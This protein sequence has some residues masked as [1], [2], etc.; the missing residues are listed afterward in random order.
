MQ[1]ELQASQEHNLCLFKSYC[2][3]SEA[4]CNS[5]YIS[6]SH[7]DSLPHSL[8]LSHPHSRKH[9][10]TFKESLLCS[11]S[12]SLPPVL[13]TDI[14]DKS[15]NLPSSHSPFSAEMHPQHL[16]LSKDSAASSSNTWAAHWH[17]QLVET[18]NPGQD[19]V[20]EGHPSVFRDVCTCSTA[21]RS[22]FCSC[23]QVRSSPTVRQ[24][25]PDLSVNFDRDLE[26]LD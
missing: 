6:F 2:T 4:S 11:S 9:F 7:P 26:S 10:L 24:M 3:A 14:T 12:C 8:R 16:Q 23:M 18:C 15:L 22:S 19:Q 1:R 20:R 17:L 21:Y 5:N 25:H 13:S